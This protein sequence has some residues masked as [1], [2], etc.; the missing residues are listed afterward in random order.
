MCKQCQDICKTEIALEVEACLTTCRTLKL[1]SLLQKAYWS[2]HDQFVGCL[3]DMWGK[4]GGSCVAPNKLLNV[5]S[6]G[7]AT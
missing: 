3:A 7:L 4:Q 2:R 1:H 5:S 6:D